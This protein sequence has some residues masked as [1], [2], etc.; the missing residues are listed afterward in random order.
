MTTDFEAVDYFRDPQVALDPFAYWEFLQDKPVW[1]EP[2]HGVVMV[3]GWEELIEVL[4][5][6]E[7]FSSCNLVAGPEPQFSVPIKG[8]GDDITELVAAHRDEMP[9]SDQITTFDPPTHT[10]HRALLMGLITPKRLK[11]NEDF[12]LR[13]ANRQLDTFL[14]KGG[15]EIIN[16]FAKPYALLVVADLLGVP[17]EDHEHLLSL[18]GMGELPG[19]IERPPTGH[20]SLEPLYDYFIE[21]LGKRRE[22][23]IDDV[24][25]GLANATFP[26]G[27]MP[28]L[29]ECARIASNL[30]AAGQE[31]TVRLISTCLQILGDNLELQNRLRGDRDLI[32][33]FIEETMRF[34]GPIKGEHRL[35]VKSTTLAGVEIPAGTTL[36]LMNG[37]TGRDRRQFENP[38]EFQLER[39]NA[40][41]HLG[42]GHGP[43]TC[44]GAPLARTEVRVFLERLFARTSEFKIS[45]EHHGAPGARRYQY[46]P[47]YMFRGLM[48]LHVEATANDS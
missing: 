27:T 17:E 23:K 10:A 44:P 39:P 46:M 25:S 4:R 15:G 31:T 40:R 13:L 29:V 32:S 12:V 14:G 19:G 7:I 21:Q 45:E 8:Q 47:T 28:E 36:L 48:D 11:E 20:N 1:I 24:L 2:H 37:A 26:D 6:P 5:Q 41:R 42:F 3:S 34:E 16:D 33:K 43:H 30:F 38:D 35:A 18:T 9:Q 22:N